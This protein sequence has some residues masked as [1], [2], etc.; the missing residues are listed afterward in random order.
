MAGL[1]FARRALLA[2]AMTPLVCACGSSEPAKPAEPANGIATLS[3]NAPTTNADGSPIGTITGYTIYYGSDP[4]AMTQTIQI[5]DPKA[6]SYVVQQLRP[7]TYY[8]SVATST[9][10]GTSARTSPVPTTI[11]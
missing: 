4:T 9:A 10:S 5:A 8:F 6:T 1:S 2:I 7:G 3:W 11:H